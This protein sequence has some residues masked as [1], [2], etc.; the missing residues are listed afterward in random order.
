MFRFAFIFK[1]KQ[2]AKTVENSKKADLNKQKIDIKN[3]TPKSLLASI[4]TQ[5]H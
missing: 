1:T 4:F 3:H 5:H 2:R